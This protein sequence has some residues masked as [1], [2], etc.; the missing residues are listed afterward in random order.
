MTHGRYLAI[1]HPLLNARRVSV[2]EEASV[3]DPAHT[4]P[5]DPQPHPTITASQDKPSPS[6]TSGLT[7]ARRTAEEVW[8]LWEELQDVH[9][10]HAGP[11]SPATPQ[12]PDGVIIEV[13]KE[14]MTVISVTQ[15]GDSDTTSNDE[16][17]ISATCHSTQPASTTPLPG[18]STSAVPGLL[19]DLQLLV[20]AGNVKCHVN[21]PLCKVRLHLKKR[22]NASTHPLHLSRRKNKR[23]NQLHLHLTL[24]ILMIS[25]L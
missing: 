11:Q 1:F 23:R 13:A 10:R 24:K 4:E 18:P 3:R 15:H 14:N 22:V 7:G 21:A 9:S 8:V 16:V 25:V 6:A 2:V 19:H 20:V 12:S 17:I 5:Q